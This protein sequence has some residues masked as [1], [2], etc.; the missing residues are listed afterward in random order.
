MPSP[1]ERQRQVQELLGRA[2]ASTEFPKT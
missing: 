1:E 2:V